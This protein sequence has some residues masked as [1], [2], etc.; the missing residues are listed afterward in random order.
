MD[1]I[2]TSFKLKAE[3]RKAI[4]L[5]A[6]QQEKQMNEIIEMLLDYYKQQKGEQ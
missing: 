4:K 1:Y 6:V 5:L 2:I 3:T